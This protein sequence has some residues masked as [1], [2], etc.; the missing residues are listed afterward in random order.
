MDGREVSKLTFGV[1]KM[2]L[3]KSELKM[4]ESKSCWEVN[5]G[6]IM[7][8]FVQEDREMGYEDLWVWF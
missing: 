4:D 5:K 6:D 7:A 8:V 1:L 2:P 3:R